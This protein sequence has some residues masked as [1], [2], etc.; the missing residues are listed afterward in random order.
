MGNVRYKINDERKVLRLDGK[1]IDL[2]ETEEKITIPLYG[3]LKV[4]DKEWLYWLSFFRLELPL[5]LIDSLYKYKFDKSNILTHMR[6]D[7]MIVTFNNPILLPYDESFR[8]IARFPAYAINEAGD[9]IRIATNKKYYPKVSKNKNYYTTSSG[10][11]DQANLHKAPRQSTHRLVALTWVKN[12]DFTTKY[13]VDHRDGDKRNCHKDN[14]RWTSYSENNLYTSSQGLRSDNYVMESRDI[15]TGEVLKHHSM[16]QLCEYMGRT[17]IDFKNTKL[18]IGRIWSGRNGRF[19]LRLFDSGVPW[20]MIDGSKPIVKRQQARTTFKYDGKV[21]V[22]NSMQ[23]IRDTVMKGVV[24]ERITTYRRVFEYFKELHPDGSYSTELLAYHDKEISYIGKNFNTEETIRTSD[25]KV[26]IDPTGISKSSIQKSISNDGKY[27]FNGWQFKIDDGMDF[28]EPVNIT[29][30]TKNQPI[31][32]VNTQTKESNTFD[33]L[34]KAGLYLQV[35]RRTITRLIRT[36]SLFRNAYLI[37]YASHPI[38]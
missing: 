9:T 14:L 34:R 18:K 5:E 35:D 6:V 38:E 21:I 20:E 3:M 30:K 2:P 22:C 7:P 15:D 29:H 28:T 31:T 16:G 12:T 25:R 8:V 10:I 11:T 13:L 27:Q 23:E 24:L 26:F 33:S 4:V 19:E 1:P 17:K 32:I 37:N 36:K